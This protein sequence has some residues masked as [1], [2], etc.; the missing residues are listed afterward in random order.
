[1]V[2]FIKIAALVIFTVNCLSLTYSSVKSSVA[3]YSLD[4]RSLNLSASLTLLIVFMTRVLSTPFSWVL[5]YLHSESISMTDSMVVT[6]PLVNLSRYLLRAICSVC[7]RMNVICSVVSG[8]VGGSWTVFM[9]AIFLHCLEVS[10]VLKFWLTFRW[11]YSLTI[12]S[13]ITSEMNDKSLC[14]NLALLLLCW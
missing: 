3:N 11:S 8:I 5:Y 10:V 12:S 7:W 1:M 9:I 6:S 2:F 13:V 14:V 4:N